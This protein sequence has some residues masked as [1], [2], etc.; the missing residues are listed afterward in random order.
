MGANYDRYRSTDTVSSK[1]G[2]LAG[3]RHEIVKVGAGLAWRGRPMLRT[4]RA[5]RSAA[6]YCLSVSVL[7]RISASVE[8]DG[9]PLPA[10]LAPGGPSMRVD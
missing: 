8:M 3:Q 4:P 7:K 2:S 1:K 9:G 6:A 5:L 10:M